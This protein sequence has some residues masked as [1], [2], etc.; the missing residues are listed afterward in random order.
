MFK[1]RVERVVHAP[2]ETVFDA[3]ADHGNYHLFPAIDE[4][5][6]ISEGS[7]VAN[8]TGAFRRVRMNIFQVWE[9]IGKFERPNLMEYRIEKSKPLPMNHYKG[10]IEFHAIDA[11][12]TLVIWISE[13]EAPIP[14]IGKVLNK[15]MQ[16][17]GTAVFHSMLKSI[18]KR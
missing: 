4:S 8:G 14:V 12:R 16:K 17:N 1:I 10:R 13:G 9:R 15:Q 3:I 6:L 11:K 2:I 18:E 7:E 5:E